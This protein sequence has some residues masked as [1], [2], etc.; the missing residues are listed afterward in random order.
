MQCV[1]WSAQL[2]DTYSGLLVAACHECNDSD[3][4]VVCAGTAAMAK[5]STKQLVCIRCTSATRSAAILLQGCASGTLAPITPAIAAQHICVMLL[6]QI[7]IR[8][9]LSALC[10]VWFYIS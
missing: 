5:A 8:C 4:L 9:C 1:L 6:A 10:Q 2:Q 7:E 3:C